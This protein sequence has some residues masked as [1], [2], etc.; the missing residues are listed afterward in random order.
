VKGFED[1]FYS[2]QK[3]LNVSD[4]KGDRISGIIAC[5]CLTLDLQNELIAL[6]TASWDTP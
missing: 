2:N 5:A 1:F 3:H 6:K 4:R